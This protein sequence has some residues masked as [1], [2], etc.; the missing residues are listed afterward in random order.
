[1][2]RQNTLTGLIAI[3]AFSFLTTGCA[4]VR[5]DPYRGQSLALII[6]EQWELQVGDPEKRFFETVERDAKSFGEGGAFGGAATGCLAGMVTTGVIL[7]DPDGMEAGCMIVGSV[8]GGVAYVVGFGIGAVLG[9]VEGSLAAFGNEFTDVD[10]GALVAAFKESDPS[11]ELDAGLKQATRHRTD[12]SLTRLEGAQPAEDY[13]HLAGQ[14]YPFVIVLKITDFY[15][16]TYGVV[17]PGSRVRVSVKGEVIDTATN[18]RQLVRNW[19]YTGESVDPSKL[20]ENESELLKSHMKTA[21]AEISSEIAGDIFL[22]SEQP[23]EVVSH[24]EK[25][26]VDAENGEPEAQ[27]QLYTRDKPDGKSLTWLC[28]AADQGHAPAQEE[29]GDLHV[30]GLGQA[31]REAGLVELDHVRAYMW[32]SLAA[33]NG[34]PPVGLTRDDFADHMTPEQIAEAERLAAEWKP[35]DCGAEGSPT[36][37]T[38]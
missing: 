10:T 23:G 16:S 28:L 15:V 26:L 9:T 22:V 11:A 6:L 2:S 25:L 21:W 3:L 7:L 1:M 27:F 31:W 35:G 37:S 36:K 19:T 29:L 12:A 34:E 5:E 8:V 38:G 18:E 20:A 13:G 14:G 17:S 4:S 30:K 32:Y 33:A 24:G